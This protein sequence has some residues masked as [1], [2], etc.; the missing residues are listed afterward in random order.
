V[1]RRILGVAVLAVV[2]AVLLFGIPLALAAARLFTDEE[3]S[4]LER[5]ALR[6]AVLVPA[7]VQ[8]H[9]GP[10]A[11]P[12]PGRDVRVG[13]FGVD[14]RRLA[15]RGPARGDH[16]VHAALR[17]R[18]VD[19][20]SSSE[21]VVAVPITSTDGV[22]AVVRAASSRVKLRD[23][24]RL[25]WAAM[26]GLAVLAGVCASFFAAVQ[27]RRL[28]R[29]LVRLE[30]VA[31]DLGAG[32]FSSRAEPSGV[33]EIDRTGRALNRTAQRLDDMLARERA[34]SARAS[35]QLRTPL[36]RLRLVLDNALQTDG[37]L[38]AAAEEAIA[39]AD[40]LSRT[41]DDVLALSRGVA[42]DGAPLDLTAVLAELRDRWHGPLAAA[43]RPLTVVEQSH[44]TTVAS[45]PAVR[46]ILDVLVDNAVR[47]GQGR[48]SVTARD[49]G[50]ALAIDVTDE[51]VLAAGRTLLP[52][53]DGSAP[54]P[55]GGGRLGLSMASSLAQGVGGRLLHAHTEQHTRLTLLLA[56][57]D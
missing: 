22:V 16:S 40:Q 43:G 15:G 17:G 3:R 20:E 37:D 57:H 53:G 48:V 12:D 11:L 14:G 2:L 5:A 19:S 6:T 47:H 24:V 26:A 7:D 29:P 18:I 52:T 25:T 39:S 30:T 45:E 21:L 46:Q 28:T 44:P 23:R 42:D 8:S 54:V 36:T 56:G 34:F 31:E 51:G 27:S 55:A 49:G 1:R 9:T 10:L 41:V 4:E 50:G 38:H 35:H 32:D 33:G 13:V